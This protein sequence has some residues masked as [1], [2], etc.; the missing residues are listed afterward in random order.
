MEIYML[1]PRKVTSLIINAIAIKM[2][3]TYPRVII[4]QSGSAAWIQVLCSLIL[5]LLIFSVTAMI[6][7]SKKNVIEIAGM[8]GKPLKIITG[9]IVFAILATN[10]VSTA[11]IFPETVKIIM[12][13]DNRTEIIL[14]LFAI[15]AA[16][17]A[18]M[19]IESIAKIHYLF[20]PIAGAVM[21]VFLILLIPNYHIDNLMPI[22]GTGPENILLGG[23]SSMS[24]FSDIIL[25]NILLP[26]LEGYGDFKKIGFKSI[27]IGGV[28]V[29]FTI[30][31]YCALY[32]YPMSEIFILPVYQMARLI[33]LSNFFS[34]FES[35]FEFIWSILI[36]LYSSFYL[37]AMCYVW[38]ITFNLRYSKPLIAPITVLVFFLA[39]LPSSIMEG[40]TLERIINGVIYPFA[41]LLPIIFGAVSRKFNGGINE[42]F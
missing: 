24:I 10:L 29:M 13:Q 14:I 28:V 6:Y 19:G 23:V 12:L 35:F 36:L 34:R 20:L 42:K 4:S 25:I 31:A 21:A 18:Y 17:G 2:L 8:C 33:N 15:S 41:F 39:F 9:L 40:M 5:T 27:L 30:L 22:L 16:I 11:R 38:Q 1:K 32:A 37:Y 7:K 26:Y 3:L